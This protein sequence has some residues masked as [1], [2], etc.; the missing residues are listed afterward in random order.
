MCFILKSF[1]SLILVS[2]YDVCAC[3]IIIL[4]DYCFQLYFISRTAWTL[5]YSL[6][7][8]ASGAVL[9]YSS[10]L[11]PFLTSIGITKFM[12]QALL[13]FGS[14]TAALTP[15]TQIA[16]VSIAVILAGFAADVRSRALT[17]EAE[18]P[19]KVFAYYMHIWNIF[20]ACY[21]LLPM[22]RV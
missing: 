6:L 21:L 19:D 8:T 15:T 20:Y 22:L 13:R 5:L 9:L 12:P 18:K 4:F 16:R 17:V 2:L 10:A 3:F 14:T 1:T 11:T 7:G